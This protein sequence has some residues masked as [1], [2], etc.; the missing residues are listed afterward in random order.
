MTFGGWLFMLVSWAIIISLLIF[1]YQ[2]T[3]RNNGDSNQ[4]ET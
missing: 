1:T 2:R 4:D 3:I